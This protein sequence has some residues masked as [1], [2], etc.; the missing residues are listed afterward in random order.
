MT[1]AICALTAAAIF[2]VFTTAFAQTP[3]AEEVP[4]Q[5]PPPSQEMTST[6]S[7]S[8]VESPSMGEEKKHA[9]P[10]KGSQAKGK[11]KAKGHSKKINRKQADR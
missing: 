9:K 11:G 8:P 6:P 7:P 2:A 3:V 1:K 5:M 4:V 10:G